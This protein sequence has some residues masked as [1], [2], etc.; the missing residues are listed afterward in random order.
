LPGALYETEKAIRN[1]KLEVILFGHIGDGNI[2]A[3]IIA[4]VSKQSGLIDALLTKFGNIA[5]KH[6]GSV[7]GE[8]GIGLTK[9]KLLISEMKNRKSEY[10][11]KLMRDIKK[12]FDQNGILNKGKIFD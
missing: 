2:H 3:N 11:I 7:S 8:H 10:S 6:K 4:D 5:L 1:Q 12:E 9:K